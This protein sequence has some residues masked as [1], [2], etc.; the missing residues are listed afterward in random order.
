MDA[1]RYMRWALTPKSE[2]PM[3]DTDVEEEIFVSVEVE[4]TPWTALRSIGVDVCAKHSPQNQYTL[5]LNNHSRDFIMAGS[6]H[7]PNQSPTSSSFEAGVILS[8]GCK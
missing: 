1:A 2:Y 4:P 3:L 6:V 8:A 7:P 5:T